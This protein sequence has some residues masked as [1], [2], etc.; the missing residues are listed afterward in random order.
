[1]FADS[2]EVHKFKKISIKNIFVNLKI[3]CDFQKNVHIF[4]I[5]KE[6]QRKNEKEKTN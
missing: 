5:K 4:L 1:M 3:V 2:E 6:I